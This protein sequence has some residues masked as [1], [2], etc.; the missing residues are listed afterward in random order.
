MAQPVAGASWFLLARL[1]VLLQSLVPLFWFL[2]WFLLD[3]MDWILAGF[4]FGL[5]MLVWWIQKRCWKENQCGRFE[6]LH[7][8]LGGTLAVPHYHQ[9]FI[10][11]LVHRHSMP[12]VWIAACVYLA[13]SPDLACAGFLVCSMSVSPVWDMS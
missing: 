4:G 3:G 9:Y 5:D 1:A 6:G 13:W 11:A 12:I 10:R 2:G 7:N 8:T